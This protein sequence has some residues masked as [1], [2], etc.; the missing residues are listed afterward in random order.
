MIL[1][2]HRRP[3]QRHEAL[4]ED[5]EEGAAVA[6]HSVLDER[7]H[8]VH[9]VVHRL[10]SQAHGQGGR[11]RQGPAQHGDLFVFSVQ[12]TGQGRWGLTKSPF[13]L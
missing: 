4:A 1:V 3:K 10:G 11:L 8:V 7:Q 6:L 2:R 9:Q 13:S 5:L 12:G